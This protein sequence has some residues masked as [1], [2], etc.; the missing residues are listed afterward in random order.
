MSNN[1]NT[2]K[3]IF[4]LLFSMQF[5]GIAYAG[6][7]SEAVELS[8]QSCQSFSAKFT[9]G[10]VEIGGHAYTNLLE[11]I[12]GEKTKA[13]EIIECD[14]AT[15]NQIK[16]PIYRS[17]TGPVCGVKSYV[18]ARS[19][20]CGIVY[21]AKR[22]AQCGIEKRVALGSLGYKSGHK[23]RYCQERNYSTTD[24]GGLCLLYNNCR[25]PSFG[26]EYNKECSLP[27]FGI[28]EYLTCSHPEF[29]IE[30]YKLSN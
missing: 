6:C 16:V 3:L 21:N 23:T 1:V 17:G 24:G 4:T 27:E 30:G 26:V 20:K 28:K 13:M 2:T 14:P 15:E 25:L 18:K 7:V 8:K 22:H 10:P 9:L 29:G 19:P 12:S 5:F 11:C